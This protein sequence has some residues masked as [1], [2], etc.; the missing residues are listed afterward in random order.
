MELAKLTILVEKANTAMQ[1][2][3]PGSGNSVAAMFNPARLSLTRTVQWQNQ[4]ATGRD[5]PEMQYTGSD[6]VTLVID[7]LF[8]T[9]D[10]PEPPH[11]KRSVK[12][13]Y[14]DKLLHLTTVEKH[15]EKH[16]PPICRLQWGDSHVFF[17]G[18]LQ[19]LETTFTMFLESGLP[20]RATSRC[21]FRQWLSNTEDLIKQNLMSSDVAKVWVVERG[22]TLAGIAAQEYGDPRQWRTIAEANRIDDPLRLPPGMLLQLPARRVPWNPGRGS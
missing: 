7:L 20:V 1:F 4:G 8:D 19:Q 15:G 5:N 21:S 11:R 17:Q 22:Q 13:S 18:V 14:T 3:A 12:T 2:D 6:P 16:R 10:T 9:Y